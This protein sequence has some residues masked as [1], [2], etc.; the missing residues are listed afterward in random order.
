MTNKLKIY[1]CS[2]I[3]D[4]SEQAPAKYWTDETNTLRNTQAVNSLL[5]QINLRWSEVTNLPISQQDKADTLCDMDVLLVSLDAAKRYA[6]DADKLKKAGAVIGTMIADGAFEFA[7][8]DMTERAD[9]LDGLIDQMNEAVFADDE[10]KAGADWKAFWQQSIIA[11]NKCGLNAAQ[12]SVAQK[13]LK[14]AA[15]QI[16]GIGAVDWNKYN[17]GKWLENADLAEMLTAGADYFL[18]TYFTDAQLAKLPKV[19]TAKK[20]KQRRTY[21][22]CKQMFVGEL[23][24]SEDDMQA[25]IRAG[26]IDTLKRTPEE[27]CLDMMQAIKHGKEPEAV[28]FLFGAETAAAGIAMLISLI[29]AVGSILVGIIT[30]ICQSVADT[31]VA[32]YGSLDEKIVSSSVPADTDYSGLNFGGTTTGKAGLSLLPIALV[33]A[34]IFTLIKSKN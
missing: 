9:H 27:Y 33:G 23:Y 11:R 5:A 32:K 2:G 18:Y 19:F 26:I 15:K 28:G 8:L 17:D 14:K 16:R 6:K 31:N 29:T 7:S 34:A 4:A 30:A 13:A 22:Y 24:G 20:L 1:A 12:Q 3:G 10:T 21:N 25:I